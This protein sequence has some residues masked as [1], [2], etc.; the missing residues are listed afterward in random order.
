MT[1]NKGSNNLNFIAQDHSTNDLS[2]QE[3][4]SV[5]ENAVPKPSFSRQDNSTDDLSEQEVA[6][7]S[8]GRVDPRTTNI[9]G[10]VIFTGP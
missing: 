10:N 4:A 3:V 1:E 2:E 9:K 8:G 5:S 7:V 6:S